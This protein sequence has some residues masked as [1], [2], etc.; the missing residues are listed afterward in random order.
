MTTPT[1]KAA[2][3]MGAKKAGRPPEIRNKAKVKVFIKAIERGTPRVYACAIAKIGQST[4]YDAITRGKRYD[5][6][7]AEN[8]D[9]SD[10][11]FSEFFA[12][13]YSS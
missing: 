5:S 10:K 12:A 7:T 9:E 8:R 13:V 1:K 6:A 3:K 4:L 2:K 11:I